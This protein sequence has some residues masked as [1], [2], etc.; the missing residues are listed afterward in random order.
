MRTS[1]LGVGTWRLIFSDLDGT[2]GTGTAR[3]TVVA[4]CK[5]V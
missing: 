3:E 5:G 2:L 1:G 4:A